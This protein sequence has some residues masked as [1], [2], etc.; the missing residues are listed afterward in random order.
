MYVLGWLAL[1]LV[2]GVI[3][4]RIAA[5]EG[6]VFIIDP[7][8]GAAG[9]LAA[10]LIYSSF[11]INP[12]GFDWASLGTACIGATIVLAIYHALISRERL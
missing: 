1:G 5:V 7:A 6:P 11:A 2:E 3:A 9:A 12:A 10:G 8:L 4:G